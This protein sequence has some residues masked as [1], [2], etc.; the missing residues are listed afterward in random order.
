MFAQCLQ[1]GGGG[2]VLPHV[3]TAF[4][5]GGFIIFEAYP[6]GSMYGIFTYI[7][8]KN[9]PNVAI[10]IP[11]MDPMGTHLSY[12]HFVIAFFIAKQNKG[13]FPFLTSHRRWSFRFRVSELDR[14]ALEAVP[15]FGTSCLEISLR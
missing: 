11:Y 12:R 13:T 6:I 8:H 15:K 2:G 1:I 4:F 3:F 7:Y 5:W 14:Q 9:Q 10:Y